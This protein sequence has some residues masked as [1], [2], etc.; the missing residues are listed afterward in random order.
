VCFLDTRHM[1]VGCA[2]AVLCH[3]LQILTLTRMKLGIQILD[4]KA[5]REVSSFP[6]MLGA[7]RDEFIYLYVVYLT[8]LSVAL[9][10]TVEW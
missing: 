1:I 8:M 4:V 7:V 10:S 5:H 3:N 2:I 9:T 6:S